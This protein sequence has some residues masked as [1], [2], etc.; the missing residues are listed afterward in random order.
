MLAV[1][2]V[3]GK[4][5]VAE[6]GKK[7]K[8]DAE[9]ETKDKKVILSEILVLADDKS[10]NIGKPNVVGVSVEAEVLEVKK[11]PKVLV[12]KHHP[13]KRYRRVRGHRQDQTTLLIKKINEKV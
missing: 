12:V 4:Q 5:F 7:L 1:V 8:I 2:K 11:A 9:V 6:V 3:A 10:V 13:K